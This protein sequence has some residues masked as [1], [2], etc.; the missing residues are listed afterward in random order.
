MVW[1]NRTELG[2]NLLIGFA[3]LAV[4]LALIPMGMWFLPAIGILAGAGLIAAVVHP[5]ASKLYATKVNARVRTVADGYLNPR[6]VAV[7][8]FGT[9]ASR[10]DEVDFDPR[11]IDPKSLRF[12]PAE[13]RPVE[14][15]TDPAIFAENIEDL[16]KDG[17]PDITV[18]FAADEAG[19]T[20]G[21][22]EACVYAKTKDGM[23]VSGC[24]RVDSTAK[25]ARTD[26]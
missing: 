19:I 4:G 23:R 14:D 10:G 8:L 20:H 15:M 17:I 7:T 11:D 6:T 25:A 12:G 9:S 3:V 13:A 26:D 1:E 5:A 24:G 21:V 2:S 22:D 18:Y 16:N